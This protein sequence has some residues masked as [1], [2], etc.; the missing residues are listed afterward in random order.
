M[1]ESQMEKVAET[2]NKVFFRLVAPWDKQVEIFGGANMTPALPEDVVEARLAGYDGHSRTRLIPVKVDGKNTILY[3]GPE[4]T[5]PA[6]AGEIVLAHAQGRYP[7]RST[8]FYDSVET[9]AKSQE[10][11]EPEDRTAIVV[12]QKGNHSWTREMPETRFALGPKTNQYF[13]DEVEPIGRTEVPYFDL[14][15]D[16]TKH[17]T[18]NYAWFDDPQDGSVLD[19]RNSF[20]H[21]HNIALGV[22]KKTAKGGSHSPGYLNLTDLIYEL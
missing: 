19:C 14:T 13:N 2:K 1:T 9:I 21:V 20:L 22:S 17:A 18:F 15:A 3:K 12:A 11:W 7:T 16:S 6:G 5:T 4:L 8:D 10:G